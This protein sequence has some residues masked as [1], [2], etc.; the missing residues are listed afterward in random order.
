MLIIP[1]EIHHPERGP[2]VVV[3]V[4]EKDNLARMKQADPFDLNFKNYPVSLTHRL[5]QEVDFVI[6]YEEDRDQI[7]K[8]KKSND[9]PGLLLWL[10]RGRKI[11]PGDL[12]APVKL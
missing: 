11:M 4:L 3:M 9:I 10:E 1:F 12:A 6:A 8:F 7:M 2:L 5:I